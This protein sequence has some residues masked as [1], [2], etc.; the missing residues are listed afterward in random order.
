MFR[1]GLLKTSVFFAAGLLFACLAQ[2]QNVPLG[3][4]RIH[5]PFDN[6]KHVEAVGGR[7]FAASE[8][9][10]FFCDA[11][12]GHLQVLSKSDGFSE[13]KISDLVYDAKLDVLAV[14]YESGNLDLLK[15]GNKIVNINTL[16]NLDLS[17]SHR[18]NHILINKGYAYLSCDIG[19]V[20]VNIAKEE[21][22]TSIT[23]LGGGNAQIPVF[24]TALLDNMLY[25]ATSQGIKVIDSRKNLQDYTLYSTYNF[26]PSLPAGSYKGAYVGVVNGTVY[27]WNGST[28]F[29]TK[30]GNNSWTGLDLPVF[31]NAGSAINSLKISADTLLVCSGDSVVKIRLGSSPGKTVFR[32]TALIKAA[33]NAV[34]DQNGRLWVADGVNGLAGTLNGTMRSF[35]IKGPSTDK[36]F[37]LYSYADKV[38][39][40]PGGY[41][42]QSYFAG[43]GYNS[44]V[45]VFD[46]EGWNTYGPVQTKSWPKNAAS[47]FC[48]ACYVPS[49]DALY[50]SSYNNGIVKMKPGGLFESITQ[51]SIGTPFIPVATTFHSLRN[52]SARVDNNGNVWY[53]VVTSP[54][55]L[56]C[57][58]LQTGKWSYIPNPDKS[59]PYD[60]QATDFPAEMVITPN[61]D[62]WVRLYPKFGNTVWVVRDSITSKLLSTTSG[63]GKLPGNTVSDIALDGDGSVWLATDKGLCVFYS[64]SS[65]FDTDSPDAST[66]IYDGR[67]VLESE[68]LTAL[69]IDGGGRK[70]VGTSNNGLWLFNKDITKAVAYFNTDNSPLPSNSITDITINQVTGEVFIATPEG[71]V[72]YRSSG[73]GDAANPAVECTDAH[74][75]PNPVRPGYTGQV[76]ITGITGNSNVKITD[77]AGRLAYEGTATGSTF[78]WNLKDYNG[79]D[80]RTGV[81][82][83][84]ISAPDG[85]G[86]CIVNFAVIR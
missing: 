11:G 83:A 86:T 12:N 69:A 27:A 22:Y 79:T 25:L 56:V 29:Y 48:D 81:Y 3:T 2:A 39:C 54:H 24:A 20:V 63:F 76:A 14:A 35:P 9:G 46:A 33:N 5:L 77:V 68:V 61:N 32:D 40:L 51:D 64:P 78:T 10:F 53:S 31:R 85:T 82:Y 55:P 58:N 30:N 74:V 6:I 44:G 84:F 80:A 72:S 28:G 41:Y 65:I 50:I 15:N 47:D 71:L 1:T 23:G 59:A 17:G 66:P 57:Q 75:F 13:N 8:S 62:K 67:P 4:W 49:E 43:L 42:Y 73:T 26:I 70:W 60:D 45:S 18:I 16:K 38:A 52:S 7:I 36:P 19:L 34:T 37:R 21:I